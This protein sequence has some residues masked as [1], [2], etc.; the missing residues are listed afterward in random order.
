MRFLA[1]AVVSLLAPA[2]SAA[3]P[4]TP[5]VVTVAEQQVTVSNVTPNTNVVL[6]SIGLEPYRRLERV[7]RTAKVLVAGADGVATFAAQTPIAIRSVW[8]A[9]DDASGEYA[10][11]SRDGYEIR[12][13]DFP[14]SALK[15]N[16]AGEI[17]GLLAD[18]AILHVAVIRAGVG[19][20]AII[21]YEGGAGDTDKKSDGHL[22]LEF[23][24]AHGFAAD[25]PELKHLKNGDV[26][27]AVDPNTLETMVTRIGK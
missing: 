1:A 17:E 9:V 12:R 10:L 27:I 22:S 16:V 8:I 3:Q 26:V 6:Y 25:T 15:K 4:S 5:P 14:D 20:W 23:G 13:I 2:L 18:R 7:T 11:A 24:L 19:A 21:G